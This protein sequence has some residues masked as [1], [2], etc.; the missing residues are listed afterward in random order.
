VVPFELWQIFDVPDIVVVMTILL[1]A[2]DR[3]I[4]DLGNLLC[5]GLVQEFDPSLGVVLLLVPAILFT[6]RCNLGI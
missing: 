6:P 4:Q 3:G 1:A 5:H 2:D